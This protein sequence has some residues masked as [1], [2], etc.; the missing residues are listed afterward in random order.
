MIVIITWG[1]ARKHSNLKINGKE[2]EEKK[3]PQ[4]G[5]IVSRDGAPR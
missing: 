5:C 1:I 3:A 2:K 4:I